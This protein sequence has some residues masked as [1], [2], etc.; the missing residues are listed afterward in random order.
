MRPITAVELEPARLLLA[1]NDWGPRVQDPA[2]F[3]ELVARSQVALVAVGGDG[4]V[5]G[6]LRA[7][8]DGIFNGYISMVV[9]AEA[10]RGRGVGKA[11]VEAAMGSDPKMTWVLRSRQP[12]SG[13]YE[14]LGF[15]RSEVAMERPGRR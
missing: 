12:V 9:V 1:A 4:E 7:L 15:N 6:F 3:Q 13:F 8:T 11:L 5:I 14:K 10:H 2:V